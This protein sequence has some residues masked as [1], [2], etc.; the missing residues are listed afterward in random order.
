MGTE[1]VLVGH[2]RRISFSNRSALIESALVWA[3]ADPVAAYPCRWSFLLLGSTLT[4][5]IGLHPGAP[6]L[7]PFASTSAPLA[8]GLGCSRFV[9]AMGGLNTVFKQLSNILFKRG[10]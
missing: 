5:E 8:L 3:F 2:S 4:G 6:G 9:A 1:E 7:S 10:V